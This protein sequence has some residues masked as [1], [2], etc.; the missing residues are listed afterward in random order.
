MKVMIEDLVI[1]NA[2]VIICS[3]CLIAHRMSRNI[4]IFKKL[5]ISGV[6]I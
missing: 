2:Y 6:Q 4:Y 5:N 1:A 3:C